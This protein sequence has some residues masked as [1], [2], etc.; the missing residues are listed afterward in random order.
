M[1]RLVWRFA[2]LLV[3]ALAGWCLG[4]AVGA[5]AFDTGGWSASAGGLVVLLVFGMAGWALGLWL[6]SKDRAVHVELPVGVAR[7][8]GREAP[9]WPTA[10]PAH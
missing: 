1:G 8:S 10:P 2:A 6:W 7:V 5:Y 3:F 4:S 9:Q